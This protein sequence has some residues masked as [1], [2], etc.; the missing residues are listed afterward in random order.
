[1]MEGKAMIVCM[2]REICVRLHDEIIALRPQWNGADPNKGILKV[3]MTGS[4]SDKA[5]LRPHIY[6]K[7]TKNWLQVLKMGQVL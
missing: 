6:S 7:Q 3:I 4:S 5:L 2:S 1:V